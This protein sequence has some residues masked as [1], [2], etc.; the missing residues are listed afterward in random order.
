MEEY[1][2]VLEARPPLM[3]RAFCRRSPAGYHLAVC[4]AVLIL[5]PCLSAQRYNI[6]YTPN[7]QEGLLL[8]LIEQLEGPAKVDQMQMFLQ[9]YPTH[10]SVAWIYAFLQDYYTKSNEI[11][12]ALAAGDKLCQLNPEDLETAINNQKLAE[13]KGDAAL[14]EKWK[15]YA[16]AAAQKLIGTRKPFY[17]SDEE[18]NK[19]LEYAGSLIAQ[20]EYQIFKAAMEAEKAADKIKLFEE[21]IHKHANSL[22]AVQALPH[23]MRAY[24]A[25]GSNDRALQVAEKILARDPDHDDALLMVAQICLDKRANYPRVQAVASRLL[26]LSQASST[27]QGLSEEDWQKRKAFYAGAAHSIMGNASVFQNQFTQADKAFRAALPFI[28]GNPQAEAS[29]YFYLGYS[30]YY[31]ENYKEAADF[32]RVCLGIPGPFQS[33]AKRQLD[34]MIR[35]KRIAQDD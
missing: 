27:P 32:F 23:L 16:A 1:R 18:W 17:L 4:I 8:Q 7:S 22:Y 24:R 9:K 5:A 11:D 6:T 20:S 35:E 14:I 28:K 25:A 13:K 10:P 31:L 21:L 34:G 2:I 12:K 30:N 26:L 29:A 33:Q 15:A 3:I 19:R